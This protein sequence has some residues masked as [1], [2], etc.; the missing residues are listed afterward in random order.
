MKRWISVFTV[1]YK[2][3][4]ISVVTDVISQ[5]S[6]SSVGT[7]EIPSS[8]LEQGMASTSFTDNSGGGGTGENV[9]VSE[10]AV[11]RHS[12][13]HSMASSGDGN[14]RLS[15]S[16]EWSE[17][18]GVSAGKA[19]AL[20]ALC[21]IICSKTSKEV[22]TDSQLAQFYKVVYEALLEKDR[23]MLCALI[24]FGGDIF[25]LALKSVEIL[26][27]QF[28]RT[29]ETIYTESVKSRLHPSI[30]EVQM[31]RA[32]LHAL[33]TLITA[34]LVSDPSNPHNG[35]SENCSTYIEVRP[36]LHRIL[37]FA[38]CNEDDSM[39]LFL[40]LAL[41]TI[42]CEESC[43]Y[44]FN[45]ILEQN[46]KKEKS[47]PKRLENS[48]VERCAPI[49]RS[50]VTAVCDNL[51]KPQWSSE[52]S[53]CLAALDCL[54]TLS[55]I[56]HS[57]LFPEIEWITQADYDV[58]SDDLS[59]GLLIVKSL[60]R[61]I[62]MQ[63]MKPPP[64]HSK[65]LHSSVVAAYCS[66]SVCLCAAPFLLETDSCLTIVAETIEFGLTGGKNLP[67]AERKAASKRVDD[68]A[69]NLLYMI[70]STLDYGVCDN[71]VDEKKLL[72]KFDNH[73]MNMNKFR[74]FLIR[75]QTLL[76][77]HEA[78]N[79]S[80]ICGGY[81]FVPH[82][83]SLFLV[84]R[85]PYHT[86]YS[87]LV[88]L[89]ARLP[90]ADYVGKNTVNED[91]KNDCVQNGV[92]NPID[93][94]KSVK[95]FQI[96]SELEKPLCKLDSVIPP[97]QST[98]DSDRIIAELTDIRK[99]MSQGESCLRSSDDR[100]V[101]LREPFSQE[102]S[103][104]IEPAKSGKDCNAGRVL[105]YDLGLI[106]EESYKSGDIVLLD[107]SSSQF[108]ND[109]HQVID[110]S[111]TKMLQSVRL[112]Y[113]RDG[114]RSALDILA[115]AMDLQNTSS[116]FCALLAELGQGVEINAHPHWTGD[117]ATA[118]CAE[119]KL[120]KEEDLDHYVI[121]GLTHCLWWTDPHIEIAFTTPTERNR[122]QPSFSVSD[123]DRSA[124]CGNNLPFAISSETHNDLEHITTRTLQHDFGGRLLSQSSSE[125][126]SAG[127]ASGSSSGRSSKLPT[128]VL[129][130][131]HARSHSGVDS[132]IEIK[133]NNSERIAF[134]KRNSDQ[135]IF[136]VFLERIEDM[137]H[138]PYEEMFPV[139]MDNSLCCS[140]M[141]TRPDL[142]VIFISEVENELFRISVLGDW[143]KC[144]L[145]GPL[146]DGCV[147]SSSVLPVLLRH[148]IISIARR[149]TVE[150]ENYQLVSSRRRRAIQ[151]FAR[152]YAMKKSYCD[153]VESLLVD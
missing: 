95:F 29:V 36:L 119:R 34:F 125:E 63:L 94:K 69:E 14:S 89:Q 5:R 118:F 105:L 134:V 43:L 71:F 30:D 76:S 13:A 11:T 100:N 81:L 16:F 107:S 99:R 104:L 83:P 67:P 8:Y 148:T 88:Q 25:R 109:L 1:A 84:L 61:F 22:I 124:E 86:A 24:Y 23:L 137:H 151:E 66:L 90:E 144:G 120:K 131:L 136:V 111:P 96:P 54:N 6:A 85:T 97:L 2:L 75:Q 20:G 87:L 92:S 18:D 143:T 65:D 50:I 113:V 78:T 110:R 37:I 72:Y 64:L 133:E 57:V 19:A 4:Q 145:P 73:A 53:V 58:V 138:F 17:V 59:I 80:N 46:N 129:P 56:H 10:S 101:W 116:Q 123:S 127:R 122:K 70:F 49:I 106:S 21:R 12:F 115:N 48:D 40:I 39:N 28:V 45:M 7:E 27:P 77:I 79:F 135:R 26:L 62:D 91:R 15:C 44:D 140:G 55:T 147:V 33:S 68:A 114:Q 35:T 74:Y 32:C 9:S 149:R 52:L 60:C 139:T 121:D 3:I 93:Q 146:I 98:P 117:W 150:L 82:Q 47:K 130:T 112:F 103:K 31:R 152:K 102:I 141:N 126:R 38:L 51:C 153:F 41:C 128:D 108:Y 42:L 132:G 142:V